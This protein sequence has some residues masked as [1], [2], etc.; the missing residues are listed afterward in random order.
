MK[1]EIKK[2]T[3]DN[4]TTIFEISGE[5]AF[6]LSAYQKASEDLISELVILSGKPFRVII[7]LLKARIMDD[8]EAEVFT[9]TQNQAIY[10]G[11]ER[12]AFV[13]TSYVTR[14]QLERLSKSGIR[15]EKLGNMNFFD[16][17]ED[18]RAFIKK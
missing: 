11:M 3:S 9:E 2:L 14:A 15:T 12:D 8:K 1:I 16:E 7:D 4:G 13:T 6:D 18:A 10:A 5:G 17:L